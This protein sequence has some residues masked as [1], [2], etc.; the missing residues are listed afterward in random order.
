MLAL[1]SEFIDH[2]RPLVATALS[3]AGMA[4]PEDVVYHYLHHPTIET[5]KR[6]LLLN[7]KITV[8]SKAN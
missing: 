5:S 2:Q 8:C 1:C 7:P 4:D 3:T 6:D